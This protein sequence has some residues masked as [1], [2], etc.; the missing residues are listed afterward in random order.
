MQTSKGTKSEPVAVSDDNAKQMGYSLFE[1]DRKVIE[2]I[3]R[4]ASDF[5]FP[6]SASCV[7][8]VIIRS[9]I[10]E[11]LTKEDFEAVMADDKRGR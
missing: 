9:T 7:L 1:R 10:P 8:R 6:L 4:R 11:K 2:A 3:R 5:G